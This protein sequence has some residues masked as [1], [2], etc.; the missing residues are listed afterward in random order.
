MPRIQQNLQMASRSKTALAIRMREPTENNTHPE[1]A[2]ESRYPKGKEE[3]KR[4]NQEHPQHRE[5]EI[6]RM[7]ATGEDSPK[8]PE[9]MPDEH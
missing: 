2:K 5:S 8:S 3:K 6:S 9:K 1:Q 4:K 7:F